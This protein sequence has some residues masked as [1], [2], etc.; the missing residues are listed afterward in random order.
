MENTLLRF[1]RET[2]KYA[3]KA[4]AA[5]LGIS[6]NK[7]QEIEAGKM[8]LSKK[9]THQLGK[10]FKVKG[11]YFYEAAL[12]LD[13][14]LTKSEIIKIQKE[15]IEELERQVHELQNPLRNK[16]SKGDNVKPVNHLR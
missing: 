1:C 4:I 16:E 15:K 5:H 7:Y 2:Q 12:Q 6:I 11:N 14:L 8:L 13:L 3:P 9:Q 10:L